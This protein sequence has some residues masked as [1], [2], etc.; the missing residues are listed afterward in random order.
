MASW[1]PVSRPRMQPVGSCSRRRV[2]AR[3]AFEDLGSLNPNPALF[4]NRVHMQV[5]LECERV[6]PIQNSST[7]HTTVELLP[8]ARLPEVLRSGAI[9]HALVVAALYAWELWRRDSR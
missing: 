4:G 2:I 6:G 8:S 9:D 1:I 5:A 7:E 3:V